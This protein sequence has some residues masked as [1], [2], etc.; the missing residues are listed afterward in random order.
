MKNLNLTEKTKSGNDRYVLSDGE[1]VYFVVVFFG[2]VLTTKNVDEAAKFDDI[3]SAR[4]ERDYV[5]RTYK[6]R[7]SIMTFVL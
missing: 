3:K 5:F 2:H 7:Y 4:L 6:I 1:Y